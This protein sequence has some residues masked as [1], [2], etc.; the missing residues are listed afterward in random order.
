MYCHCRTRL[1]WIWL[2]EHRVVGS[3]HR[4]LCIGPVQYC[5]SEA[6]VCEMQNFICLPKVSNKSSAWLAEQ[7]CCSQHAQRFGHRSCAILFFK[8]GYE[9]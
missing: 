7:Q 9:K 5:W 8:Q 2:A 1:S 3:M 4:A 6:E